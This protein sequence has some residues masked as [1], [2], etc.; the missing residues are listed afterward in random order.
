MY[1]A[2]NQGICLLK[3]ILMEYFRVSFIQNVVERNQRVKAVVPT[4]T[5]DLKYVE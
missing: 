2:K 4:L 1:P 3:K 5:K